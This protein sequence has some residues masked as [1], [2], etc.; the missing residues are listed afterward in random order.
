MQTASIVYTGELRTTA[1][2]LQ[3]GTVIE[4]DPP[5]DNNGKGERFSPTDL[6]AAALGSCML[7]IMGIKARDNKWPIEGTKVSVQKIMGTDP[8]RITGLNVVIDFP[9]GLN[10]GEKE[11]TILERAAHTCPVAH[12]IHPE[13]AQNVTFNW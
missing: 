6:V 1:T 2:H 12:S 3:S 11:R 7:T 9:Q 8:R 4:T 13:I 10:L 5:V